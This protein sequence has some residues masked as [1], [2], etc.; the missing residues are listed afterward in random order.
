MMSG[1]PGIRSKAPSDKALWKVS[2]PRRADRRTLGKSLA[3]RKAD[4]HETAPRRATKQARLLAVLGR[5]LVRSFCARPPRSV[6]TAFV[7]DQA[8]GVPSAARTESVVPSGIGA[9]N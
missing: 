6:P 5:P 2:E 3:I 4:S 1:W 7:V 9:L 8:T